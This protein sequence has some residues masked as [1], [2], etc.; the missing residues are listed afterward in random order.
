MTELADWY[1]QNEG[2]AARRLI[3]ITEALNLSIREAVFI[4]GR[5]K[6]R[7]S[8]IEKAERKGYATPTTQIQDV[9][10]VRIVL[11]RQHLV[12]DA[13]QAIE[14]LAANRGWSIVEVQHRGAE[15]EN[16][17][18][19]GYQAVHVVVGLEPGDPA[20]TVEVQIMTMLQNAWAVL[21]HDLVYKG[22]SDLIHA[23]RA[24]TIAGLLELAEQ[25][26]ENLRLAMSGGLEG[27]PA[28]L[29]TPRDAE[30]LA[31]TIWPINELDEIH[32]RQWSAA[33]FD[34]ISDLGLTDRDRL[35][36]ILGDANERAK[37]ATKI[38]AWRPWMNG[39][40]VTDFLFRL[41]VPNYFD[42]RRD[43]KAANDVSARAAFNDELNEFRTFGNGGERQGLH[44]AGF[45]LLGESGATRL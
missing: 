28:T 3:T 38:R 29:S 40:L 13:Q 17:A 12:Q 2:A 8:F 44:E 23:R 9:A 41:Q 34:V 33:L 27:L 32:G 20:A 25:E 31:S 5:V 45:P 30:T 14:S 6:T 26:F 16:I 36:D 19:P 21:Q 22:S 43:R 11:P 4:K 37:T 35:L 15:A 1:D 10:G 24:T 39:Y 7:E 42:K 18:V